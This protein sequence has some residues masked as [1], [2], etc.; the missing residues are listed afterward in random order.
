MRILSTIR[1]KKNPLN[2]K[3]S[4]KYVPETHVSRQKIIQK[5]H[6]AR[7]QVMRHTLMD[8]GNILQRYVHVCWR[9]CVYAEVCLCVFIS[10]Y[11]HVVGNILQRYAHVCWR[12]CV[13]VEVCLRVFILVIVW[14]R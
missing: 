13:Y 9:M 3:S 1:A 6:F 5:I 12:I 10:C 11:I 7:G 2:K 4:D 14:R 8:V